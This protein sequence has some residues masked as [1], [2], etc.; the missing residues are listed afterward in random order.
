MNSR[1]GLGGGSSTATGTGVAATDTFNKKQKLM[2][3]SENESVQAVEFS[4][5][6]KYV[7]SGG[8]RKMLIWDPF[9]LKV[10]SAIDNFS[11][12]IAA[13]SIQDSV[14]IL[15]VTTT[16]KNIYMYHN[17]T[18]ELLQ[19]IQDPTHYCPENVITGLLYI[20]GDSRR[21]LTVGDRLTTWTL[22]RYDLLVY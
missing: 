2:Q 9:T 14:E 7:A 4:R 15:F 12:P 20:G 13:I 22:E 17:I 3:S 8:G 21:L 18:Y 1:G 5:L 19:C 10:I 11:S 6:G 16:D